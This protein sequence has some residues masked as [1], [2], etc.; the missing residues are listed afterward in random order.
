LFSKSA[1]VNQSHRPDLNI[2][3]KEKNLDC[4]YK[5]DTYKRRSLNISEHAESSDS[6]LDSLGRAAHFPFCLRMVEA[7]NRSAI[8]WSQHAPVFRMGF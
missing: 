1:C 7:R 3:V 6:L 4:K 5:K 8:S 2:V